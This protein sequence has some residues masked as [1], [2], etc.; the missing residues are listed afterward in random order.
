MTIALLLTSILHT[1][2]TTFGVGASTFALTFYINALMDEGA[3]SEELHDGVPFYLGK[4][5]E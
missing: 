1:I 4:G 5:T 2:G 3:I